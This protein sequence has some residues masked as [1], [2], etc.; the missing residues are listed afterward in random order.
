MTMP[1]ADRRESAG[2]KPDQRAR[3]RR[4]VA[5]ALWA[6]ALVLALLAFTI[7]TGVLPIAEDLRGTV[8]GVLGAVAALDAVTAFWF[9]RSSLQS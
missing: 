3:S 2:A 9:F 1:D 4:I 5:L 7:Y 6:G 8:A